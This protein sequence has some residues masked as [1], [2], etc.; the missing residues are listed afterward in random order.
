M[1][2]NN[3]ITVYKLKGLNLKKFLKELS[4]NKIDIAKFDRLDYNLFLIGI[5]KKDEKLFLKLVKLYH[6]EII[7]EKLPLSK[8]I[9]KFIKTNVA[10]FI[11]GIIACFFVLGCS[12]FV[13]RIE[14]YGTSSLSK[15]E[16]LNVLNNNGYKVG[17]LKSK[18]DLDSVE[19]VLTQNLELVSFA[20]CVIKG[21]TLI[22]NI[23]EKIDNSDYIY[24]YP[25][26]VSPFNAIVEKIELLSGTVLISEGKT[27]RAGD[28]IIAP[29]VM[30]GDRVVSTP[31]RAKVTLYVEVTSVVEL[32][33]KVNEDEKQKVIEENK[34]E[35]YND[36]SCYEQVG[37]FSETVHEVEDENTLTLVVTLSGQIIIEN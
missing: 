19:K 15:E 24:D 10:L 20:S 34:K 17:R 23:N 1:K 28:V 4:K 29:C 13:F 33:K 26:I 5:K 25:P 8:S 30:L 31:A 21:N 32:E 18:Y 6:Y 2:A 11:V 36:L 9:F 35:L 14:I 3:S 7:S 37:N 22:V 16:V 12:N 27:A